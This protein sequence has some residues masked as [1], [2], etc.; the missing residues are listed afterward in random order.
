MLKQVLASLLLVVIFSSQCASEGWKREGWKTDKSVDELTDET[1][2]YW[3]DLNYIYADSIGFNGGYSL[4]ISCNTKRKELQ[5][6]IEAWMKP[7]ANLL[8]LT[9]Y[10]DFMRGIE[11]TN[12]KDINVEYR[13][14]QE[15]VFKE[16]WKKNSWGTDDWKTVGGFIFLSLHP[17]G[18]AHELLRV[19]EG[20]QTQFRFREEERKTLHFD[21]RN[22]VPFVRSVLDKCNALPK[23][24]KNNR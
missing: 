1:I 2:R 19:L 3:T 21:L 11:G 22:G 12:K 10:E 17:M 4:Y 20:D 24:P 16:V 23:K 8:F 6:K 9:G 15:P 18:F 5:V 13:F 14:D 7:A